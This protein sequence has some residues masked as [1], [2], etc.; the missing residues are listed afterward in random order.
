MVAGE[1]EHRVRASLVSETCWVRIIPMKLYEE[2][3]LLHLSFKVPCALQTKVQLFGTAQGALSVAELGVPIELPFL[4]IA[5]GLG[6]LEGHR[7]TAS[8]EV[9][10]EESGTNEGARMS[11]GGGA[12]WQWESCRR[13]RISSIPSEQAQHSPRAL[14]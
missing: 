11:G 9:E 4:G 5:G 8:D 10:E 6:D 1:S 3:L 7:E 13:V 2:P 12:W 14:C